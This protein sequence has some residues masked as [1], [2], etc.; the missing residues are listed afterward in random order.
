[1]RLANV[2][3][4]SALLGLCCSA[5]YIGAAY[6]EPGHFEE[7]AWGYD[8]G[9]YGS[10][11]EFPETEPNGTAATA[12]AMACGDV[13]RPAAISPAL[14]WDYY[15]FTATVG[16]LL[17]LGTDA[18]DVGGT[19]LDS[20]IRL[21]SADGTTQLAT[22]D[23]SG[24]GAASLISNFPAPYT[25]TYYAR[26]QYYSD[27]GTGTGTYRF[28][29]TCT[30]PQ[31]PPA[32]DTC[33]GALVIE[34]CS[35]GT[36]T[37]TTAAAT[38][39][40]GA[41]LIPCTGYTA[42]G[43]DVVYSVVLQAGETL[44]VSYTQLTSDAS[45]Y[46]VTDCSNPVASCVA[47]ADATLTGV[48]EVFSYV[49]GASGTYY[50]ILDSYSLNSGAN[51]TLTYSITCPP[52]DG[53]CCFFDGSCFVV[54]EAACQGLY[55]GNGTVCDPN[56]CAQPH[57]AC[58]VE[59][60]CT[61]T[62]ALE[63]QGEYYGDGSVCD[64]SPCPPPPP[65][66][67]CCLNNYDCS[68]QSESACLGQG[69]VYYGDGSTCDPTPCPRPFGACCFEDGSCQYL[70]EEDCYALQGQYYGTGTVCEPNPCPQPPATGACC[71]GADC[72]IVTAIECET[73]QGLYLG[74]GTVCEGVVCD[75]VPTDEETWGSIKNRYR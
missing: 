28:F 6:A 7:K 66:G 63:C 52:P 14:D 45:V 30:V 4:R 51:W 67:A 12:N 5:L 34:P 9:S 23:D 68:I 70:F 56:P 62:T 71:I 2:I 61:E 39:N 32:N 41:V 53:A 40:Y 57:G 55:Q 60:V 8:E 73:L 16:T 75:P 46:L 33:A 47:G 13:I 36:R 19:I 1:M 37:G 18:Q 11:A 50:L 44:N 22:D 69:G 42:N 27:T 29:L 74:D 31:P 21:Y 49:A 65:E 64:P 25:G 38:N 58:C 24:P 26:V 17:T 43:R 10:R 20:R 3:G 54:P 35:A 48:A 15:S 59:Y 72:V